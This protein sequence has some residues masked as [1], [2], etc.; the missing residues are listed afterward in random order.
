MTTPI[1]T[2]GRIVHYRLRAS[3]AEQINRRRQDA[4]A[5]MD[6]H[7]ENKTGAQV[8]VGNE[9]A[10]NEIYPMVITKVWGMDPNSAVN[11]QVLLDGNDLYWVTST[12]CG[13]EPGKFSWPARV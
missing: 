13:D 10:E 12:S 7:R 3:D 11:G 4:R 6:W 1:P 2:I 8:H 5:K 9:A